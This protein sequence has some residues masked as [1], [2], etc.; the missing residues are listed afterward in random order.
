MVVRIEEPRQHMTFSNIRW[1]TFE[2]LLDD[3]G[4]VHR[5]VA[6]HKGDLEFMTISY[7]HDHYGTWIGRLIFFVALEFKVSICSGGSTTLKDALSDV[8]L[9]P[10][11]CFWT[12]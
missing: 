7:E 3:M 6:Y 10:D 9:E 1:D 2:R 4:E 12:K 5:R 8:G 11:E